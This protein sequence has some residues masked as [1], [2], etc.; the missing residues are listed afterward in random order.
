MHS[1]TQTMVA[2][3]L[4]AAWS[5]V[6]PKPIHGQESVAIAG[7]P[8]GVAHVTI[9]LDDADQRIGGMDGFQIREASGRVFYPVFG[10]GWAR[11]LL[12]EV[13]GAGTVGQAAKSE[14]YFLFKGT[15]PL[16]LTIETS[17]RQTITLTPT[18][19]RRQLA[20]QRVWRQWWREYSA[21]ARQQET[22]SSYPPVVETYLTSM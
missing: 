12:G 8:F 17:R 6:L 16:E 18:R 4:L 19:P 21:M 1:P 15:E 13:G 10:Q 3:I 5:W 11:R 7:E 20:A 14:V 2:A 22:Q 9:P